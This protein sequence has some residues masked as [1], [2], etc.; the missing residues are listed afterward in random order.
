MDWHPEDI[1]AAIRKGGGTLSSLAAGNG[2]S[3]QA[4]SLTLQARVS[5]RCELVIA[6]FLNV[7]PQTIWPSRYR[8]DG[9]RIG[10]ARRKGAA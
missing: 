10:N 6:K 2:V 9:S 1:K 4:M 7:H 5:A 3:A 8:P